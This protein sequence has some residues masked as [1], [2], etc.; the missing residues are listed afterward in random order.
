MAEC[1][2]WRCLLLIA[3]R[4]RLARNAH[5]LLGLEKAGIEFAAADMSYVI[6]LARSVMAIS[7]KEEA[8][9]PSAHTK[10]AIAAWEASR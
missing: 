10:A 9:A 1:C 7:A 5:F 3:K 2:T 4:D 8:S 6:R